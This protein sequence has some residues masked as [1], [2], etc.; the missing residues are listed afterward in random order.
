[1]K[2]VGRLE[3][4]RHPARERR[5]EVRVRADV[6]GDDEAARAVVGAA[7]PPGGGDAPVHDVDVVA[8][9]PHGIERGD[10]GRRR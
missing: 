2:F 8:H 4:V 1:M 3:R 5:V 6:A 10:D 9:D 7:P